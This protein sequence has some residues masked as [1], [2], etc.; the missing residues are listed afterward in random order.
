MI[1]NRVGDPLLL[2]YAHTTDIGTLPNSAQTV[3]KYLQLSTG[4]VAILNDP[5]S[6]GGLL[7]SITLFTALEVE[8]SSGH[9]QGGGA[10]LRRRVD[11]EAGIG[12]Y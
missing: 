12:P 7:S 2:K 1:A 10:Q 4:Q 8:G 5:Y 11:G 3:A 6:G 9:G